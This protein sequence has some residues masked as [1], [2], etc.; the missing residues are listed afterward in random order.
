MHINVRWYS[1]LERHAPKYRLIYKYVQPT[2]KYILVFGLVYALFS[3]M[4]RFCPN[5]AI[6]IS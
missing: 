4:H 1:P 6:L 3:Q 5:F 2:L